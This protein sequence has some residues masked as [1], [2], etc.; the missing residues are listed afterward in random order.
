MTAG[1]SRVDAKKLTDFAINALRAAGLEEENAIIAARKLIA[2]DLRGT[3]T[4]GVKNLAGYI[5]GGLRSGSINGNPNPKIFSRADSTATFDGDRGLGFIVGHRAM[6]EAIDRASRT[7]AGFVAVR[8]SSHFG[9]AACYA[10][11]ALEH[12]MI[13]I[14][15]TNGPPR[16]VA[17]GSST[18]AVGTNPLSVAVPAGKKPPFVLDMSTTVVADGKLF[19]A[20][21]GGKS[22]PE[23]WAIDKEG[24]PLT[25]PND[26]LQMTGFGGA[27]PLGGT[28][29]HGAYKGFGLGVLVDILSSVLS[30]APAG[31]LWAKT[32]EE[33]GRYFADHFFGAL[34]VD[35][36]FPVEKFKKSMD[37]MITAIEA[38]KPLPGFDKIFTAGG[39]EA[40]IIKDRETNG[41]P[42]R[43][44]IV[45]DLTDLAKEL[46]I[47]CDILAG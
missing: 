45:Q 36:F 8:N 27:L 30:G 23:G 31:V 47:E 13:G 16:M 22:I 2:T 7:G 18:P 24:N 21:R 43:D 38:F 17:P 20:Q 37:D 1:S 40:G 46:G 9:A 34:L 28:P 42:L 15:V 11:M 4:H 29:S 33:G 10:T 35:S 12:D 3:D 5:R 14:A 32:R 19:I 25:D 41:I 6:T 44:F 26:A 39:Y